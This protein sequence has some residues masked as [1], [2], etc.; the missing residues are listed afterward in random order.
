[1][2]EID[3]LNEKWLENTALSIR[4]YIEKLE[5]AESNC[6]GKTGWNGNKTSFVSFICNSLDIAQQGFEAIITEGKQ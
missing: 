1:M 5:E 3:L 2:E 4:E 6:R